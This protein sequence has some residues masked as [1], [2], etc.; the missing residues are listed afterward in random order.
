MQKL[1]YTRFYNQALFLYC[2][3]APMKKILFFF[4]LISNVAFSQEKSIIVAKTDSLQLHNDVYLGQD[5]YGAWYS[6]SENTFTKKLK[7]KD[8][9]YKN[10]ALGK[11][12]KV[13]LQN[14]L[15]IVLFY[16]S[17]NTV[18]I[19]D[20]QL[21]ETQK[22]NFGKIANP[23]VASAVGLAFGNRLWIYNTLSQKIGLYDYL[24]NDYRE[25]STPF[26]GNPK[27]YTSDFNYF[28]W[29]DEESDWYRCDVYGKV[30]SFGKAPANEQIQLVSDGGLVYKNGDK[31][32][33]LDWNAKLYP[34][35]DVNKK[36][37]QSFLYKDKILAIFTKQGITNYKIT[38][39]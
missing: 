18:V 20:N 25:I 1:P 27:Y 36:T 33:Y 6:I 23:V 31:L 34:L 37:Y 10:Q 3:L 38:L 30:K 24:K 7:A 12:S 28:Q 32:Y 15:Q 4:L 11:I 9:Q 29:I 39:P 16:E 22:I 14:P 19:L 5:V 2:I 17:F 13:D 21:N 8:W 26:R 35:V